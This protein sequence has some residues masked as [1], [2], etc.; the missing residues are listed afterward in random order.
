MVGCKTH[1]A[2]YCAKRR[3]YDIVYKAP[4]G[5]LIRSWA[6]NVNCVCHQSDIDPHQ[7]SGRR[8]LP[9]KPRP[10]R[11]TG[12]ATSSRCSWLTDAPVNIVAI[13]FIII[14]LVQ[15]L[16]P[17]PVINRTS[18]TPSLQVERLALATNPTSTNSG[19]DRTERTLVRLRFLFCSNQ[20]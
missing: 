1:S 4:I 7:L 18:C 6:R 12:R 9:L 14:L 13:F 19:D 17:L 20:T 2:V 15:A 5:S 10:G 3:V 11:A 16:S 8:S